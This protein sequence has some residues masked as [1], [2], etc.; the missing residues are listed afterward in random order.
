MANEDVVIEVGGHT[1]SLPADEYCDRL[2]TARAKAVVEYL[3]EKGVDPGKV[4]F[5]GYGKKKPIADNK[6]RFGRE[7]NQRVE[8]K[9]LSLNS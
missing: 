7:K 5:K 8:I 2:S 3:I 6:T 4:Q 1:N 9:I